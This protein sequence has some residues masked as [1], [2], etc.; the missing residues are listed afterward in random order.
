MQLLLTQYEFL[1]E[2]FNKLHARMDELLKEIPNSKQLLTIKRIGRD[3]AVGFLAAFR[4][5]FSEA[6]P[7]LHGCT[8]L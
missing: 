4:T 6:L 7:A 2:Q 1:Q 5:S 3:T 8:D